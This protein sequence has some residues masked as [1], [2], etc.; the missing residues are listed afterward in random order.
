MVTAERQKRI[1]NMK[2]FGGVMGAF[3]FYNGP[4]NSDQL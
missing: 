4:M 2:I 3:S 1:R